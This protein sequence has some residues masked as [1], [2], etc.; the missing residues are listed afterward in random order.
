MI[1][2]D[3][4]LLAIFLENNDYVT[5]IFI[6]YSRNLFFAFISNNNVHFFV[7]YLIV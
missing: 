6:K 4:G 1:L 5:F 2:I 3:L 7:S